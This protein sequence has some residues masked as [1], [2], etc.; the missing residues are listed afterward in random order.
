M[1]SLIRKLLLK[2]IELKLNQQKFEISSIQ[3]YNVRPAVAYDIKNLHL[4]PMKFMWLRL[5]GLHQCPETT[6]ISI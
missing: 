5:I 6:G 4:K 2:Q 1:K 3:I